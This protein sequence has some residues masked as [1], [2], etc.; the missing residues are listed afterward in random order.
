MGLDAPVE[1]VNQI[2]ADFLL[3]KQVPMVAV[4]IGVGLSAKIP[5]FAAEVADGILK[6]LPMHCA[7]VV[8]VR[9]VEQA[10]QAAASGASAV[11]LRSEFLAAAADDERACRECVHDVQYAISG[12]D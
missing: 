12:D 6:G 5:G 3:E 7:S 11:L 1:V 9:D 10:R 2:E 8:G 4:N